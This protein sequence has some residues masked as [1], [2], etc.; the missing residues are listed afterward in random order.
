MGFGVIDVYVVIDVLGPRGHIK[1]VEGAGAS[2]LVQS[3]LEVV[4]SQGGA[5]GEASG[6]E[7]AVPA[8]VYSGDPD[9]KGLRTVQKQLVVLDLGPS[10]TTI[11]VTE[12]VKRGADERLT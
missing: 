5:P 10:S 9:V 2:L 11:S 8:L 7:G 3:H 1:A 6:G 4:S 12:L